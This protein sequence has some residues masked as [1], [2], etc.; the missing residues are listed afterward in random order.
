MQLR[1]RSRVRAGLGWT[2]TLLRVLG[3]QEEICWREVSCLGRRGLRSSWRCAPAWDTA[4]LC[5]SPMPQ[6]GQ[7]LGRAQDRPERQPSRRR[8]VS[9]A[10]ICRPPPRLSKPPPPRMLFGCCGRFGCCGASLG[11][12][13]PWH[14]LETAAGDRALAQPHASPRQDPRSPWPELLGLFLGS[15][16]GGVLDLWFRMGGTA[17]RTVGALARTWHRGVRPDPSL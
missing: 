9:T 7:G 17:G 3:P 2:R 16:R 14:T 8:S 10:A 13:V 6:G 5:P 1:G 12:T 11:G 4:L 15:A